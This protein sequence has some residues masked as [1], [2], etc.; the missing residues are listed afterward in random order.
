MP[1][2]STDGGGEDLQDAAARSGLGEAVSTPAGAVSTPDERVSTP[3]E[4]VSAPPEAA[5]APGQPVAA[6]V[7]RRSPFWVVFLGLAVT[8]VVL[9]Q[10]TKA[11]IVSNIDPQRPVSVIGDL[12]RLIYSHN[13]GALFGL[14]RDSAA[15]F[16]IA[17]VAVIAGIAWYHRRAPRSLVLSIALGLLSGGAVGNLIDRLS[18]GFVVDFVDAGIGDVRFYTFNVADSAISTALLLLVLLTLRPSLAG[19]DGAATT[20]VAAADEANRMADA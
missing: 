9:D 14:F 12:L 17:S 15:L 3:D 19:E 11:W 8:V 7:E 16:A 2:S 18:R 4:R 6:P 10:L 1:D 13:T 20:K 5:S